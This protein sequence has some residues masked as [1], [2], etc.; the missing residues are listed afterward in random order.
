MHFAVLRLAFGGER[1]AGLGGGCA[2]QAAGG[3]APNFR[4]VL[5]AVA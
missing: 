5:E 1:E 3:V 2:E 4:A